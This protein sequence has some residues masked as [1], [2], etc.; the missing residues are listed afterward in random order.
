ML[1]RKKMV[2]IRFLKKGVK[3]IAKS[4]KELY[5]FKEVEKSSF[6]AKQMRELPYVNT[7]KHNWSSGGKT[8]RIKKWNE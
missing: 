2:S 3:N 6:K 7:G 4:W 1:F 8:K 5:F